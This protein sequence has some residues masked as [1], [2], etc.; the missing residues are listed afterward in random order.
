MELPQY[1]LINNLNFCVA[2]LIKHTNISHGVVSVLQMM[3]Q[4]GQTLPNGSRY[5]YAVWPA[6]SNATRLKDRQ[7]SHKIKSNT[8]HTPLKNAV[9]ACG[10]VSLCLTH[11][12]ARSVVRSAA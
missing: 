4:L 2:K 12:G 7:A 10:F 11:Q 1:M 5:A 8:Q 9:L 3:V 6:I